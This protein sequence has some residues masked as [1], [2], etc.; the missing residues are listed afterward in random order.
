M[1]LPLAINI[2]CQQTDIPPC[3]PIY[4]LAAELRQQ[5]G[6]LSTSLCLGFPYADVAEMGAATIVVTDDDLE[7][8]RRLAA[9][10]AEGWWQA[11]RQ[12]QPRLIGVRE[13][14]D[15]L[16]GLDGPVCLLDMGDNVG[17]GS[18][19]DGTVLAQALHDARLRDAFV[20]LYDPTVVEQA[21]QAGAG[22]RATLAVG[23]HCD[24]RHGPPLEAAFTVVGLYEGKFSEDQPRHG[25]YKDFDQGR[26]AV[27]RT[28][29]GLSVMLTLRRMAPFSLQ[30]LYSCQLDPATFKVLV[31]KGVHVPVAAYRQVCRHMIRVNTPG[32]TAADLGGFEYHHRRRPMFPF[33]TDAVWR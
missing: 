16:A 29:Q 15:S 7:L 22:R 19:G 33:E 4:D 27:V 28:D 11:R 12:F 6:V 21:A 18:P 31:A 30:Q 13:V 3:R 10:L 23:G 8:A 9:Q 1:Q 26:T 14:I 24:A 2:E 5:P 17:G 32:V 25:G 20:C